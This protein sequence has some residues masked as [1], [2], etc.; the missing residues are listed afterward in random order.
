MILG[1][2]INY[3]FAACVVENNAVRIGFEYVKGIGKTQAEKIEAARQERPFTDLFDFCKRTKL[4]R[5]LVENLILAGAMDSWRI[6]RRKLS[7]E[8]GKIGDTDGMGL[9]LPDDGVELDPL[10]EVELM[11]LELKVMGLSTGKHI[12]AHYR[13]WM[14]KQGIVGSEGIKRAK[15]GQRIQIAGEVVMHQAPPTAK[16]F[17]FITLM[18]EHFEMMNVIVRPRVYKQF[19]YIL[20]HAPLQ[21][22][23][24]TLQRGGNVTNIICEHA[25]SLP[26]LAR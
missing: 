2:D 12:M 8:L 13:Q 23:R 21:V 26:A 19:K 5:R 24:G 25:S 14:K 6:D 3:S 17:H 20:R 10:S 1:V 4:S 16:G 22:I 15:D 11:L 9:I 7:W 18:D